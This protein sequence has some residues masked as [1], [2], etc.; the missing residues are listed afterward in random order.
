MTS[1]PRSR[2]RPLTA[3]EAELWAFA[4]REAKALK[5]RGLRS[6]GSASAEQE[7][8]EIDDGEGRRPLSGAP[9]TGPDKAGRNKQ[10]P[11]S[12]GNGR[13]AEKRPPPLAHFEERRRRRLSRDPQLI[14]ARL[15]LHGMRQG[16]AHRALR[17]FLLSCA[18][19]GD[20]HVLVI[21]G[22]GTRAQPSS[23][24]GFAGEE[25][26]VLKRLVPQWLHDAECRAVVLSFTVASA[27]HGGE[28][29]LYVTLR[30]RRA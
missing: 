28:G 2:R 23:A 12:H 19:R 30:K 18:A 13:P 4:T 1:E 3:D 24:S 16:E 22:K 11:P 14:D 26:G 21:T 27:R 6:S 8:A 10:S 5:K 20:R 9:P 29:A 17:S 7:P 25:R 15:D